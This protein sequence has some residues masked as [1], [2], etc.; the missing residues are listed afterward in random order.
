MSY[1]L[2]KHAFGAYQKKFPLD[3]CPQEYGA[4]CISFT[5]EDYLLLMR[6]AVDYIT[7]YEHKYRTDR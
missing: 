3:H 4:A 2:P 1:C 7:V 5:Y 6:L